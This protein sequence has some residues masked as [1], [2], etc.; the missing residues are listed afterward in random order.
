[1]SDSRQEPIFKHSKKRDR[2]LEIL[3]KTDTH[4]TADWIYDRVKKEF[5]DL[6]MGTVYRN[7]N[8]LIEQGL[9]Q[10]FDFGNTFD[11]FDAKLIPHYHFICE[12]CGSVFDLEIPAD[13]EL[14][15]KINKTTNFII[16]KH[17]LE[18][19]GECIK[20]REKS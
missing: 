16:K 4:P 19:F 3:E 7:L 5:P 2:I 1:M 14:N 13:N 12:K 15:T 20:C 11:R 9:V 17:R 6:S 8:I 18:F 10:K